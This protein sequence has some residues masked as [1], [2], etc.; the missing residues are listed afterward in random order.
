MNTFSIRHPVPVRGSAPSV[1]AVYDRRRF[2]SVGSHRTPCYGRMLN[3]YCTAAQRAAATT[4]TPPGVRRLPIEATAEPSPGGR[5][6]PSEAATKNPSLVPKLYLGTQLPA[7]PGF[8]KAATKLRGHVR[9][10]VR[11]G[12]EDRA[13]RGGKP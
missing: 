5:R 7:K 3:S 1:A 12:N 11:P 8:A 4:A 6:L 13:K 10:Q 9:S 2:A